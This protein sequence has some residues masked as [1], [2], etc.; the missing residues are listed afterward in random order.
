MLPKNSLWMDP[1]ISCWSPALPSSALCGSAGAD[2]PCISRGF[3]AVT[4]QRIWISSRGVSEKG[5]TGEFFSPLVVEEHNDWIHEQYD[6]DILTDRLIAMAA[7][8]SP[9]RAPISY[10]LGA[11]WMSLILLFHHLIHYI[12]SFH[13]WHWYAAF[14]VQISSQVN[15]LTKM[16]WALGSAYLIQL[17]HDLYPTRICRMSCLK[18][19][20]QRRPHAM[21][22]D[23]LLWKRYWLCVRKEYKILQIL[24]CTR[25][26]PN[27]WRDHPFLWISI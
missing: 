4:G 9:E 18:T 14:N 7:F 5:S 22:R 3:P 11:A 8:L 13:T 10:T 17:S 21:V 12:G 26:R 19:H 15:M 16:R 6:C 24:Q 25:E 27:L 2:T 20:G 1:W 23:Y